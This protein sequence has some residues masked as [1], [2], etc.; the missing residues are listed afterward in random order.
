MKNRL[1]EKS[2]WRETG[3]NRAH[4]ASKEPVRAEIFKYC[5]KKATAVA[6]RHMPII[7]LAAIATGAVDRR[8]LQCAADPLTKRVRN[9]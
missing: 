3:H 4:F 8:W 1:D 5:V 2:T 9:D 6:G 7:N